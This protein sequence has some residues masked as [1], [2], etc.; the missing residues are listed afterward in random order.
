MQVVELLRA[1]VL[2]SSNSAFYLSAVNSQYN[3][4]AHKMISAKNDSAHHRLNRLAADHRECLTLKN[5]IEKYTALLY[6]IENVYSVA[7]LSVNLA[8]HNTPSV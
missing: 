2:N 7:P 8:S 3:D 1:S 4:F 5:K 6:M